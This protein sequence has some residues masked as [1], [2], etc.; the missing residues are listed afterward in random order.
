MKLDAFDLAISLSDAHNALE[1][2]VEFLQDLFSKQFHNL[3]MATDNNHVKM[4]F[5]ISQDE[6]ETVVVPQT[7]YMHVEPSEDTLD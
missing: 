2:L 5:R 4:K 7:F 1:V 6:D 3:E